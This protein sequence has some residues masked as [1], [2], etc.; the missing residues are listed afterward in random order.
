MDLVK[1][2]QNQNKWRQW[3]RY[4]R[5]LPLNKD[6]I[7]YDLGCSI[8]TFSKLL[9]NQVGKVV[10][11][12]NNKDLLEK[13]IT[14]KS[15]NCEFILED[16]LN[17]NP[18][19]LEK[20]DGIWMSF[21][22][23]YVENPSLFV[24]NWS[25]CLNDNGWIAIV[26]IDNLFSGHLSGDNKYLNEIRA[27][28]EESYK[29]KIYDFKIGS[30]IKELMVQNQLE[31]VVEEEDWYDDELNFKGSANEIILNNWKARLDRMVNLKSVLGARYNEFCENFL[32]E[33]S[34]TNHVSSGC[35][36]FYVGIKK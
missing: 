12:D 17:I 7:I 10:G 15:V 20:C 5:K 11:Y 30:K 33:I 16:I 36:K 6:Q 4:L 23:A 9:S 13:A 26:D 32:S 31:I 14:E 24:S 3:E 25:K 2:Y 18:D 21:V 19:K 8:G 34:K 29:S 27:F 22:L 35:V 1:E 28:E